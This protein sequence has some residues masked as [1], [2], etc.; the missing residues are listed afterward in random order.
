LINDHARQVPVHDVHVVVVV[1][2]RDGGNASRRAARTAARRRHRRRRT[3][4][5]ALLLLLLLDDMGVSVLLVVQ[6][7]TVA[8]TVVSRVAARHDDEVPAERL[9]VDDQ[10]VATASLLGTVFVAVQV[11]VALRPR[12][13]VLLDLDFQVR[14]LQQDSIISIHFTNCRTQCTSA[15]LIASP[16]RAT[17][18]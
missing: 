9:E 14:L 8:G 2:H 4:S 16:D 18:R 17:V 7:R 13:R 6:E 12:A 11:Q 5:A 15:H 3:A 10:R 1:E